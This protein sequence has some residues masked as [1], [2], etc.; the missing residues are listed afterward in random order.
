MVSS[1]STILTLLF[2]SVPWSRLGE[3]NSP[4][5]TRMMMRALGF[6]K[7]LSSVGPRSE[8]DAGE[9]ERE[10]RR[11]KLRRKLERNERAL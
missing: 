8:E 10:G 7:E 11:K 1:S 5:T 2:F 3:K 4:E 9:A 6:R